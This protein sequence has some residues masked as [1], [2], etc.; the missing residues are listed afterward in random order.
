MD[1][2]VRWHALINLIEPCYHDVC[3]KAAKPPYL[4]ATEVDWFFWTDPIVNL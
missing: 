1:E 3:K 2:V 4:M